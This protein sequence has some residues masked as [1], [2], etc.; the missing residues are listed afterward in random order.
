MPRRSRMVGTK[1]QMFEGPAKAWSVYANVHGRFQE[2]FP[3]SEST[4]RWPVASLGHVDDLCRWSLFSSVVVHPPF[5]RAQ[6]FLSLHCVLSPRILLVPHTE[7]QCL[8]FSRFEKVEFVHY[9]GFYNF[10]QLVVFIYLLYHIVCILIILKHHTVI[11]VSYITYI[12][13]IIYI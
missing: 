3:D 2:R 9:T 7:I 12:T 1:T 11:M 5:I 6:W 13:Y 10:H 8:K 4:G